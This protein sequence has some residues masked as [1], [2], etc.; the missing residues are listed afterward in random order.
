MNAA[1]VAFMATLGFET[2]AHAQFFNPSRMVQW[3]TPDAPFK[4]DSVASFLRSMSL[5]EKYAP[6]LPR[7]LEFRN[8]LVRI[9]TASGSAW[10]LIP[11]SPEIS[12]CGDADCELMDRSGR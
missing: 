10:H 8:D 12:Y 1:T 6:P 5:G 7:Y 9:T 11:L 4:P 2:G 3:E